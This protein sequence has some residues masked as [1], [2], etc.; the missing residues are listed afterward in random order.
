LVGW[1]TDAGGPRPV[2]R[3]GPLSGSLPCYNLY[4]TSDGAW[5]AVAP[6]ESHFW[7]RL[8]RLVGREDLKG[9]LYKSG[10]RREMAAIFRSK[11]REEW[12]RLLE[13]QDLPIEPVLS[14]AEAR[15]HPQTLDRA[16]LAEGEDGLP[17]LA[18]PVRFD[19]QRLQGGGAVPG[20]GAETDAVL[21]ELGLGRK[22]RRGKDGVGPRFSWRRLLLRW[23]RR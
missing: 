13:G 9:S 19:G 8:C 6:L 5:L 18:F 16:V 2:G 3:S 7:E 4:K 12:E 17:R 1:A 14:A 22:G 10:A 15:K 21:A 11:S 23:V 20:V